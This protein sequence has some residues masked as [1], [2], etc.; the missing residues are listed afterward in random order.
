MK[1]Q[2]PYGDRTW[3][4]DDYRIT[5]SEARLQKRITAGLTPT[6][7]D[8]AREEMDPDAWVA[9]LAIA[10]RRAGLP[11]DEAIAIDDERFELGDILDTTTSVLQAR[12]A[13]VAAKDTDKA[14][15]D[16]A[17]PRAVDEAAEVSEG[18]EA[19]A[20]V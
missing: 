1:W 11:L 5:A 8:T 19:S 3:E 14:D 20:A 10:R 4:F 16:D 17:E 13:E 6:A 18:P 7:A 15:T 2:I 9:A 12:A